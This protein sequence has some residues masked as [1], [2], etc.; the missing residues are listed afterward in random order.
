MKQ[1]IFVL[2]VFSLFAC[3]KDRLMIDVSH[4]EVNLEINR[5]EQVIFNSN[6]DNTLKALD[7]LNEFYPEFMDVY[8]SDVIRIGGVDTKD[9][10]KNLNLFRSDTVISQVA[11]SVFIAFEEFGFIEEGLKKGLQHFKYYFPHKSIP[12]IFTYISGFN[13]SMIVGDD[14]IGINLDKYLGANCPFYRYL[15]IQRY[16]YLRMYPEKIVPDVF[17]AYALTEFEKLETKE[18]LLSSMIYEGKLMYFTEAM[19]PTSSDTV[20]IGYTEK[21]LDWCEENEAQMWAYLAE[22]KLLYSTERM[23]LQ[24]YI[25]DGPFT[26][27]FSND[28]PG[29]TGIW[30]GWQIVRS[31]MNKNPEVSISELMNMNNSQEILARAQYY[32]N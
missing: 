1:I 8:L 26:S 10:E 29:K 12:L 16:K 5:M 28:S 7:T 21:Q 4:V 17:Y 31:F 6:F 9:F 27:T 15:G 25:G 19:N 20:L 23:V 2:L 3:N 22:E 11:D 14:F 24:K 32:P 18:N 13:Q 30:I